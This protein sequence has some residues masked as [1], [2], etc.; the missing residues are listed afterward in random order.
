MIRIGSAGWSYPD[1]DGVVYP[2]PRPRDF[3]PLACLAAFLD[4][5]EINSSF[6]RIPAP[7][8]AASWAERVAGRAGFLFTAKLWRGFTHDAAP[9]SA[10]EAGA[11]ERAFRDAMRPL[12]EA[13]LLGAVLIQ[14]PYSFHNAAH[15]RARLAEIL[16]RFAD[17]PLVVEVRHASWLRGEFLGF[18]RERGAGFCNIDQPAVSA[19]IPPTAHVT[20]A[21]AYVRLHGRNAEAWFD[22]GAGRDRRYDY[23]YTTEELASWS[24]RIRVLAASAADVFI[25]A[26]NHYRGQGVANALELRAL[27]EDRTVDAPPG[28]LA[29]YPHLAS[30]ARAAPHSPQTPP[31][32]QG[33]LPLR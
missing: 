6:Y 11:A 30:R 27:V 2:A 4:C 5:V 13:G 18:L 17:F 14:F 24:E 29:A 8:A 7:S 31:P 20:G 22:E 32:A 3:D 16:E 10:E 1:W 26:N 15:N 19:N 21:P 33:I 25:I 9:G 28:I 12:R 23:L